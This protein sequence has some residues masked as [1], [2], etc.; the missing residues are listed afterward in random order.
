MTKTFKLVLTLLI[1]F[2][3]DARTQ[4]IV[5]N[6]DFELYNACPKSYLTNYKKIII[7]NWESPSPGT[8]DYYNI[9]NNDDVGIPKNWAG[10]REANSGKGYLGM[11][12]WKLGSF[13][14]HIQGAFNKP[15]IA[16]K[17]YQLKFSIAHSENA[18]H[19]YNHINVLFTNSK[20]NSGQFK[21]DIPSEDGLLFEFN[22]DVNYNNLDEWQTLTLKFIA[23]GGEKYITIGNV[24]NHQNRYIIPQKYRHKNEPMLNNSAYVYLDNVSILPSN[25]DALHEPDTENIINSLI[26]LND[27]DFEFNKWDLKIKGYNQLD[28]LIRKLEN[29]IVT[30][31]VS[32][33][34]DEKGTEEYNYELGRK[35]ASEV[36][37]YL[38]L[39]ANIHQLS[40]VS[41]GE[42]E[43]LD[44]L[45][46]KQNRRVEIKIN[47]LE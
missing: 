25:Q 15:L 24:S 29:K 5:Q 35:R 23:R 31:E 32:G 33:H 45:N 18:S 41:Y 37:E 42:D 13:K 10:Y 6:G 3:Y 34:T 11:Y 40:I 7:N 16:K 44:S 27:I 8:P 2:S 1:V 9:C 26:T 12:L 20:V 38:N 22:L 14:E 19:L 47:Y 21:Y 36:A 43:P 46:H 30:I 28:S 4:N 39:H 17:E